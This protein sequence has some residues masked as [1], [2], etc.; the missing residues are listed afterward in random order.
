MLPATQVSLPVAEP[1]ALIDA[2]LLFVLQVLLAKHPDL[3]APAALSE[4]RPSP[5]PRAARHLFD[6]VRELH[7]ALETYRSSLPDAPPL[8]PGDDDIPF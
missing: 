1:L 6:A 7:H 8:S 4:L 5:A 2:T 3:L